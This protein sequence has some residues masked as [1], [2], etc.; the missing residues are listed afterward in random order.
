[1]LAHIEDKPPETFGG[2]GATRLGAD[3]RAA[4]ERLGWTLEE[5]AGSLRIRQIY[6]LAIEEGR[7]RDLPGT[8]YAVGFVRT[9]AGALGFD[10]DEL[11]RRFRAEVAEVNHR[12]NL[13]F[14][15]PVPDRGVPAGALVLL[16]ALVAIGAYAGWYRF[17]GSLPGEPPVPAV[18]E[19]LAALLPAPAPPPPAPSSSAPSSSAPA[20][21]APASLTPLAAAP[22]PLPAAASPLA[23]P[24]TAASTAGSAMAAT[25]APAIAP[26]PAPPP[27]AAAPAGATSMAALPPPATPTPP[28]VPPP[29]PPQ[30]AAP[31][32]PPTPDPATAADKGRILLRAN[33]DSW[34]QVRD[35]HGQVLLSRVLRAGE[36]WPVPP[37]VGTARL[38]LTTGNA[39]GTELLVDGVSTPSLGKPGAVRRDLPLDA[40]GIKDGRLAQG[41]PGATSLH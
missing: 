5:I 6:L 2:A 33:A 13:R 8:A 11:A 41:T 34:V 3:L 4:R 31:V 19:H 38:L 15:A 28:S 37:P 30:A 17:S 20:S 24:P 16:G 7:V 21:P 29:A 10:A 23:A 40:D 27:G 12:P 32:V 18:P 9:Y 35:S 14:P 36:S 25:P 39:G 1:M 26:Q 22:A